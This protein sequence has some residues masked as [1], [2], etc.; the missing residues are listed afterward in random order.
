[1]SLPVL[2]DRD[3]IWIILYV[4]KTPKSETAKCRFAYRVMI[5]CSL[6]HQCEPRLLL[7]AHLHHE[8]EHHVQPGKQPCDDWDCR[9]IIKR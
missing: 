2:W 6:Q 1:M 4:L 3:Y 5:S 9:L 8:S 7:C